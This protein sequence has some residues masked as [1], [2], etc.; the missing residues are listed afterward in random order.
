LQGVT[1]K[2]I[3]KARKTD[4][5]HG[6]ILGYKVLI[7]DDD[8]L[9]QKLVF[10][11]LSSKGHACD[12]ASDGLEALAKMGSRSYDAVITDIVMPNM[13]GIV[14]TKKISKKYPLMPVMVMTAFAEEH[15]AQMAMDAG[16]SDFINKPFAGEEFLL[17]FQKMMKDHE[18]LRLAV[19]DPLTDI[20]NRRQFNVDLQREVERSSRYGRKLSVVMLDIDRF[21]H[22]NDVYG[23]QAGD[24][25]LQ[26]IA[27]LAE[28]HIR[29]IDIFAR[30]GG[31]E[32]CI[33]MPET[34]ISGA[35]NLAEKLRQIIEG[36]E[37]PQAK[38]I[39]A[40]LGVS[41]YSRGE[42][43]YDFIK[44]ADDALYNAKKKGR[45]RVEYLQN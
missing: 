7:V 10:A 36:Y 39:T 44:R 4:D 21:K 28:Q 41:E 33:L 43:V 25:V 26:E 30:Y 31:E 24:V 17:R 11:L 6:E 42:D 5:P 15:T 19:K 29:K 38:H 2:D 12:I 23:H 13:D 3:I 27:R 34:D 37:F 40:S 1:K 16:A 8:P 9:S 35:V 14:L 45:N 20:F 22:V 32:F 18:T